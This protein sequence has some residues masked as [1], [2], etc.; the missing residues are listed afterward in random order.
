MWHQGIKILF[1]VTSQSCKSKL[2]CS[3][4]THGTHTLSTSS[5]TPVSPL[6]TVQSQWSEA[7]CVKNTSEKWKW[8]KD[9]IFNDRSPV[10]DRH[11]SWSSYCIRLVTERFY[12]L[13]FISE[14]S[15]PLC[16]HSAFTAP[17]QYRAEQ[18]FGFYWGKS[19]ISLLK[20]SLLVRL[21]LSEFHCN[22]NFLSLLKE[23]SC[24]TNVMINETCE[25]DLIN[26]PVA[27]LRL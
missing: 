2:S 26:N 22:S 18:G 5:F 13:F 11:L 9:L 6:R 7:K 21:L 24:A 4:A 25:Q 15:G 14:K 3:D 17:L 27:H 1:G 19:F 20:F 10:F 12:F 23:C 8:W 16:Q